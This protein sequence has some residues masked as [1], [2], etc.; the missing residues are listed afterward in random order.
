MSSIGPVVA[1][2]DRCPPGARR[3]TGY[4][5]RA[6][7]TIAA[8]VIAALAALGGVWLEKRSQAGADERRWA[9]ED[10]A[11]RR[12]RGEDAAFEVRRALREATALF[13]AS[14]TRAQG[15]ATKWEDPPRD[16]LEAIAERALDLAIEIPDDGVRLFVRNAT[17]ALMHADDANEAGGPTPWQIARSVSAEADAVIGAY[18]RG[19]GVPVATEVNAA[20]AAAGEWRALMDAYYGEQQAAWIKRRAESAAAKMAEART[21]EEPAAPTAL[22]PG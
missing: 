8:A 9:R 7:E 13:D 6:M 12:L 3:A 19:E 17:S 11:R 10:T 4:R 14:W 16:E 18:R 20:V 1:E 15:R 22:G 2:L 5:E 21:V